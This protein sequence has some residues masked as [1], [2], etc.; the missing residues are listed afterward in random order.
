MQEE[1]SASR[2]EPLVYKEVE[3]EE[4]NEDSLRGIYKK[5]IEENAGGKRSLG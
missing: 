1:M 5:K 2:L 3:I 4:A